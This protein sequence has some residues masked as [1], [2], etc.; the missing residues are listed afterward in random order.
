MWNWL[1]LWFR[2]KQAAGSDQSAVRFR[3]AP[4]TS[5]IN[6]RNTVFCVR[7]INS[8]LTEI[9]RLASDQ[10]VVAGSM[11]QSEVSGISH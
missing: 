10:S 11:H 8:W 4:P 1:A 3:V 9:G 2:G 5:K 7:R 6:G